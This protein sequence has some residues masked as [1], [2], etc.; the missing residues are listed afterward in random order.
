MS[1]WDDLVG[2]QHIVDQLTATVRG[3]DAALRG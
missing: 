3:S 2:Q 1:V